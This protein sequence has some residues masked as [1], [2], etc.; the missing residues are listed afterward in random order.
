MLSNLLLLQQDAATVARDTC[1]T[2]TQW[3]PASRGL[4][5]R[6]CSR[7]ICR[8]SLILTQLS[9]Q[10][11]RLKSAANRIP[12][13]S[14]PTFR[15][16]SRS[17]LRTLPRRTPRRRQTR[18]M[19]SAWAMAPA[20][21]PRSWASS[22]G[23]VGASFSCHATRSRQQEP[24]HAQH[25]SHQRKS[26]RRESSARRRPFPHRP[27]RPLP[28][29]PTRASARR[30]TWT[31]TCPESPSTAAKMSSSPTAPLRCAALFSPLSLFPQ[32]PPRRHTITVELTARRALSVL[33][34]RSS[35]TA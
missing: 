25:A 34:A 30:S 15:S 20:P 13:V 23:P 35:P 12:L 27:P 16:S 10:P 18:W 9:A 33:Y 26:R 14:A 1:S 11:P 5:R 29:A 32:T 7:S 3:P 21:P 2:S 28:Q 24:A 19:R 17:R 31:S 22:S 6:C 8:R 4:V